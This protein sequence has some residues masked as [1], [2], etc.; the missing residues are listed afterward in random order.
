MNKTIKQIAD[1]I[2]VSK[3]A[4]RKKMTD[5]VKTKFVET[6]SGTIRIMPEGVDIIKSGFSTKTAQ[7]KFV[8]VST[9]KLPPVSGEVSTLITMLQ[10][11]LEVKNEQIANL[12]KALL[13]TTAALH[14]AQQTANAAQALHAG[15][16]YKQLGSGGAQPEGTVEPAQQEQKQG[17]F[18]RLFKKK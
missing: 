10:T 3:T 5:E 12:N 14:D 2:G 17:L 4:V 15:T 18:A 8:E 16:M 7:T 13:E 1:E 9:N 11:E 6:V